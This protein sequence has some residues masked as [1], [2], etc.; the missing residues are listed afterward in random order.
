MFFEVNHPKLQ[1]FS[2]LIKVV[3]DLGVVAGLYALLVKMIVLD[4]DKL[5]QF[6]AFD[7]EQILVVKHIDITKFQ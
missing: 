4:L 6:K 3:L 5:I 7:N 1:I 2:L